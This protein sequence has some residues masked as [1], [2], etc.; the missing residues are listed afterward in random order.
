LQI[1]PDIFAKQL[2]LKYWLLLMITMGAY[3]IMK[4]LEKQPLT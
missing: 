1:Y 2:G 4:V 3:D